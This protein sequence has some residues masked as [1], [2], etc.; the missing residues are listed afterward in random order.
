VANFP[1]FRNNKT[2]R[3]CCVLFNVQVYC[4][5]LFLLQV[6]GDIIGKGPARLV[7]AEMWLRYVCLVLR[8][9]ELNSTP[10]TYTRGA[11]E[12]LGQRYL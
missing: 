12:V 1:D 3:Y 4:Y 11:I 9:I 7:W 5:S 8:G 6:I 10:R 2:I